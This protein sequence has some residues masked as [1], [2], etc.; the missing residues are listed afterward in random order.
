MFWKKKKTAN[1]DNVKKNR[2]DELANTL[3]KEN[4]IEKLEEE[5]LKFDP[6]VLEG[7]EKESW[8]HL[9]GIIPYQQG[10]RT[11]A[12]ERFK[13]GVNKCPD[14]GFLRFSLGQEYEYC[15]NVEKM[16]ES[17]NM[18]RFPK[19]PANYALAEA[20]YAY[21]WNRVDDGI[22]FV[23]PFIPH[24]LKLKI[25]DTTFLYL[26]GLP[27]FQQVWSY[28]AAFS[29][30]QNNFEKLTAL[31]QKASL[32]CSDLDFNVLKLELS[33]LRDGNFEP[34]KLSLDSSINKTP[35]GNFPN[36]YQRMKLGIIFAQEAKSIE[37]GNRILDN[38]ELYENDFKWLDDMRLLAK[39]DLACKFNDIALENSLQN[40]FLAKQPLL[41]EPDNAVA[42]NLLMYQEKLK[43]IYQ[44]KH[45]TQGRCQLS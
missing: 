12:F 45:R 23:E 20:R 22:E 39:C 17:F 32:E 13:D 24:Y 27:F 38:I 3:H 9:Y 6:S 4:R 19:I 42:F 18:A 5:L 11:L 8:Y 28:L 2:I 10:N 41:F 36:G 33:A 26:R 35:V 29:K 37:E 1:P 40:K 7:V 44:E 16:I 25:L 43:S 21:L 15:G 34:L 31:T 30:L 14:S